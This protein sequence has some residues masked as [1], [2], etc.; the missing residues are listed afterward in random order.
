LQVDA[1]DRSHDV[2]AK[3]ARAVDALAGRRSWLIDLPGLGLRLVHDEQ[4]IRTL[5]QQ[6]R[7]SADTRLYEVAPA[8]RRLADIPELVDLLPAFDSQP[9]IRNVG[10][11]AERALLSEELAVLNRPLASDVE[12]YDELP[13]PRWRKLALTLG[14]VVF[15]SGASFL[16]RARRL[17]PSELTRPTV[18][19]SAPSLL[20]SPV[21]PAAP[22]PVAITEAIAERSRPTSPGAAHDLTMEDPPLPVKVDAPAHDESSTAERSRPLG[23]SYA[24]LVSEGDRELQGDQ[25]QR[26]EHA[27]E[28]ALLIRPKGAAAMVGLAYT[29]IDRG[30]TLLAVSLFKRAASADPSYAE[31][32]FG[33]GEAYR[34]EH[35][36]DLAI[37]AFKRY[38]AA[39]PSGSDAEIAKRQIRELTSATPE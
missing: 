14:V 34:E 36:P 21:P 27:Y 4:E 22:E 24:E 18:A 20:P 38:L 32:L 26:A 3:G 15:V 28:G 39:K 5:I 37:E 2:T 23:K 29:Q 11:S 13:R 31:A 16:L 8:A 19:T 7:I 30:R 12:Y 10:R 33:L 9:P 17:R 25:S 35:R 1:P 6:A